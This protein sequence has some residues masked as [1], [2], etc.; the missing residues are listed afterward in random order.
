[1]DRGRGRQR[2]LRLAAVATL[3]LLLAPALPA[4]PAAAGDAGDAGAPTPNLLAPGEFFWYAPQ[5]VS[6][7]SEPDFDPQVTV[8]SNAGI[9]LIWRRGTVYD[10]AYYAADA[11]LETGLQR[12]P[13]YITNEVSREV[14]GAPTVG[15][16]IVRDGDG[17]FNI[18]YDQDFKNITYS[19]VSPQ[20]TAVVAERLV[21]PNDGIASRLPSLGVASDGSVHIAHTDERFQV[22]D[23]VYDKLDSGGDD[24]WIDRVM[25][26]DIGP[27]T[28]STPVMTV[29]PYHGNI[30]M[31][32]GTNLGM[33][34]VRFNKFG[35]KDMASVSI[36]SYSD[37]KAADV[38]STPN[39]SMHVA[40]ID[41]GSVRYSMVNATGA[42][43]I[44]GYELAGNG[45]ARGVP[46]LAG[47]ADGSLY[48]VWEQVVANVS[49]VMFAS[50]GPTQALDQV[51]PVQITNSTAGASQPDVATTS[52]GDPVVGWVDTRDGDQEVYY[53]YGAA[54]R[55]RIIFDPIDLANMR[56]IHPNE[57]KVLP[58]DALNNASLSE[59]YS[60][61]VEHDAPPGWSV[62]VSPANLT[63]VAPGDTENFS[64]VV[65]APLGAPDREN[66]TLRVTLRSGRG[67]CTDTLVIPMTV[68][69][70]R[71][72]R[73]TGESQKSGRGGE[74]VSFG[75]FVTNRGDIREEN[76][77][78]MHVSGVG[79]DWPVS[80]SKST[81]ALDPGESTNFTVY[82][83]IPL[84]APGSVPGLFQ[85]VAF[86]AADPTVRTTTQLTVIPATAIDVVLDA[87][88]GDLLVAPGETGSYRINV[89][90]RGNLPS[91]VKIDLA[92]QKPTSLP[93]WLATL[94]ANVVY[95]RG[96][97]ATYVTLQ[98]YVAP[99]ALAGTRL[100]LVVSG[101]S[102]NYAAEGRVTVNTTVAGVCDLALSAGPMA[103]LAPGG[104][105]SAEAN[106]QNRGN[107]ISTAQLHVVGL[108][109]DWGASVHDIL[110]GSEFVDLGPNET[111][112]M[113]VSVAT[114][115]KTLAGDYPFEVVA[116]ADGCP[117]RHARI[118]ATVEAAGEVQ[119]TVD[120]LSTQVLPGQDARFRF[121]VVNERNEE[122]DVVLG[123]FD[124]SGNLG[125]FQPI[126]LFAGDGQG[127]EGYPLVDG[128]V[129]LPPWG[130]A[131]VDILLQVPLNPDR[132]EVAFTVRVDEGQAHETLFDLL[133]DVMGPDLELASVEVDKPN[134]LA[135]QTVFFVATVTN[136]GGAYSGNGYVELVVDG[137]PLVQ[138]TMGSLQPRK[139]STFNF[140]WSA[141]EGLHNLSFRVVVTGGPGEWETSNDARLV[142]V[143]VETPP[144]VM[145]SGGASGMLLFAGA[146]ASSAVVAAVAFMVL[147]RR[148]GDREGGP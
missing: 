89:T 43:V 6:N 36:R 148:R 131:S 44:D 21:G 124:R 80:V 121:E 93:G 86:S 107:Q 122:Q 66:A 139:S 60:V 104:S 47:A 111:A 120:K 33:W 31:T 39:G 20:G 35:T 112:V 77:T 40:W 22:I 17:N 10:Q 78:I 84:D 137:V 103:S 51:R 14:G 7:S 76:I 135:G 42:R 49:Q 19:K 126:V 72:L 29:D 94:D 100:S 46:R 74:T 4:L 82:I 11:G 25:T 48:I 69:V 1:M 67:L 129:H 102:Q 146:L 96:G 97:E 55:C 2:H 101:F 13:T 63:D 123:L 12:G 118:T 45:S 109:Q 138:L 143:F 52:S 50:I 5:R 9:H 85:I 70:T 114:P 27:L 26:S 145:D 79:E 130:N 28:A 37:L 140:S 88:P 91:A 15:R 58:L 87:T 115:P 105:G 16:N 56:F 132:Y 144:P 38:A 73:L 30:V 59:N 133:V 18:V 54:A 57:T 34:L 75:L 136:R 125:Q 106:V 110:T 90:N 65:H 24:V 127:G 134:P 119:V 3:L 32:V 81:A 98:V 147:H 23:I 71:A 99:G 83:T 8:D 128:Q 95:L 92:A 108:P 62:A 113:V 116:S 142:P 61:T 117:S 68:E 41:G 64:L 53:S 141:T